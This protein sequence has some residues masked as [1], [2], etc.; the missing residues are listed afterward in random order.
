VGPVDAAAEALG[1]TVDGAAAWGRRRR[2]WY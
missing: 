1:M 2:W